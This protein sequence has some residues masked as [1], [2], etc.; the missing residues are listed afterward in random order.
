VRR[1]R[2][3]AHG[4]VGTLSMGIMSG[5]RRGRRKDGC[6]GY[7]W[8]YIGSRKTARKIV[9]GP[10]GVLAKPAA[11]GGHREDLQRARLAG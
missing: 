6:R 3:S 1:A 11:R 5:G 9:E 2:S 8:L 7:G 10:M 4:E